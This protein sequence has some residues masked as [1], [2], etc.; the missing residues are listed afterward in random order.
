MMRGFSLVPASRHPEKKLP[1]I[2][3]KRNEMSEYIV[4]KGLILCERDLKYKEQ[5]QKKFMEMNYQVVNS[6]EGVEQLQ[7]DRYTPAYAVNQVHMTG[8]P[9]FQ[10]G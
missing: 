5:E 2:F 3:A 1:N 9:G 6:L 10:A 8:G 7:S 4:V